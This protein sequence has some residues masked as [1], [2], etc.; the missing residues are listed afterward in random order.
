VEAIVKFRNHQGYTMIELVI[1]MAIIGLLTLSLVAGAGQHGKNQRYSGEV[2]SFANALREAQTRSYTV[3][4]TSCAGLGGYSRGTVMD[5]DRAAGSYTLTLLCGGDLSPLAGVNTDQKSGITG[6]VLVK[7]NNLNGLIIDQITAGSVPVQSLAIAFL[8]PDGRAYYCTPDS[9]N[10]CQP[11]P[12]NPS[13]YRSEQR[14]HFGIRYE[15]LDLR[16]QVTFETISGM[17]KTAD[18]AEGVCE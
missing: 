16:R 14:V 5:Y 4:T 18:C 12:G 13:P 2:N 8:A 6:K 17:I 10:T 1:I 9:T 11:S 3:E 15:G 7:T